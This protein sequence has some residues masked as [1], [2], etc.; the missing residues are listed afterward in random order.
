[1]HHDVHNVHACGVVILW[2]MELAGGI[3]SLASSYVRVVGWLGG[4]VY[5]GD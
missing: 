5:Y 2:R 4:Y 1:M 3:L